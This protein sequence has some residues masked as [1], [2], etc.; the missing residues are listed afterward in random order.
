[1]K[2]WDKDFSAELVYKASRSSGAGGQNVNKV[3][4]KVELSFDVLNS[5]ILSEEEKLL[6]MEKSSSKINGEGILKL[7]SQTERTQLG[8][9][10]V[11]TE[12]FYKLL[13]KT[14]TKKKKRIPTKV[15]KATKEKRLEEKKILSKKKAERN[16]KTNK[17]LR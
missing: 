2:I 6:L 7:T 10:E 11:V 8:N 17:H 12:K 15:S 13:Q 14:F 5:S 4:T 3:S 9:K 1:M 16:F